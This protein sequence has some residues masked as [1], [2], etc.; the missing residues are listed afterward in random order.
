VT[1]SNVVES[2]KYDKLNLIFDDGTQLSLNATNTRALARHYGMES[3]DWVG[4]EIELT[5]GSV[6]FQGGEQE[7]VIARPISPPL[8]KKLVPKRKKGVGELNDPMSDL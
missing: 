2:E 8:E 7:T 5:V 6:E 1:I 4:K 3:D